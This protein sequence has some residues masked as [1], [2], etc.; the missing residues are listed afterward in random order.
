MLVVF[1]EWQK[2]R[3]AARAGDAAT[4]LLLLH[5]WLADHGC[6]APTPEEAIHVLNKAACQRAKSEVPSVLREGEREADSCSLCLKEEGREERRWQM[7]SVHV[8][9]RDLLY[10]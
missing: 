7:V 4:N 10:M 3:A 9:G 2:K 1:S 8:E 6:H 5:N